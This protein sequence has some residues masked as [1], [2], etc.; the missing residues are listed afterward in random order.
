MSTT[1]P[2]PNAELRSVLDDSTDSAIAG[3]WKVRIGT[4]EAFNPATQTVTV[5]IVN[6]VQVFNRLDSG[7]Q[8]SQNP[9]LYPVPPLI[10][11]PV[12]VLSGGSAFLGMPIAQGDIAIVLFNDR[13]LDPWL[14]TGTAGMPTNSDRMHSVS[15][16]IAIVGIRPYNNPIGGLPSDGKHIH[17][18][19]G[20]GNMA[21]LFAALVTALTA[22][23][24]KTGPD[25]SAP[26]L[27]FQTA[28]QGV[29]Q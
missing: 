11:V 28:Y 3:M 5:Q 1:G 14:S 12:A 21:T 15:D 19:N 26:I 9:Q 18:G 27:A 4:V 10:Q 7:S 2:I 25:A 29:F 16:G 20:S 6:P 22:L 13:D 8:I 17:F 23:N 24:A